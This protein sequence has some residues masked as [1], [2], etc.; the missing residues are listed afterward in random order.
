[1]AGFVPSVTIFIAEISPAKKM[2][3]AMGIFAVSVGVVSGIAPIVG[4]FLMDK[5]SMY[6]FF[7][8]PSLLG[9]LALILVLVSTAGISSNDNEKYSV[10]LIGAMKNK[11]VW[12]PGIATITGA[13]TIGVINAFL[14]LYLLDV[15]D[16]SVELFYAVYSITLIL[17]RFFAG[18]LSDK[19]GR[20]KVAIPS[21]LLIAVGISGLAF[22]QGHFS[23]I[24]IAIIYGVGYGS[25]FPNMA[26]MVAN[27]IEGAYHN[28]SMGVF[29]ASTEVGFFLGPFIMG[30]VST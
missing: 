4:L 10:T 2:S 9:L 23:L 12:L 20:G 17:I 7:T 26:A 6:L 14:P 22:V 5:L 25:V 27:N 28:I 8:I 19:F 15:R 16:I 13:F 18:G 1:M 21:M 11:Y 3:Q 30:I 29:S 24:M